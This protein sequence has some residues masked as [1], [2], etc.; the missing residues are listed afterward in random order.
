MEKSS[1]PLAKRPWVNGKMAFLLIFLGSTSLGLALVALVVDVTRSIGKLQLA[2][3]PL[4]Q[5]WYSLNRYSLIE[6]QA[7]VR[8]NLESLVGNWLWDPVIELV[9][10][11]PAW[12]VLGLIGACLIRF[13]QNFYHPEIRLIG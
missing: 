5:T 9:L 8:H 3:T 11:L 4:G 1:Q 6:A 13:S 12:L 2:I 10:L 7:F